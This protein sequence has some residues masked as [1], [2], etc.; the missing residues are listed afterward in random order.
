MNMNRPEQRYFGS[1]RFYKHLILVLICTVIL[2]LSITSIVLAVKNNQLKN[3]LTGY[4]ESDSTL[5]REKLAYQ[6]KYPQ[7]YVEEKSEPKVSPDKTIFLTFDDGPSDNTAVILDILDYY[8]IKAT[9]FVI[10]NGNEYEHR[11]YRDIVERGHSLAL[12]SYSHKY[13][14]IYKSVES[15]LDDFNKLYTFIEQETGFKPKIF[16]FPGGSINPYNVHIHQE[17]IAEMLRRGFIYHDWN[18][19]GND[20]SSSATTSSIYSSVVDNT[21]EF[22][23]SIVLL[24]DISDKYIT[25]RALESII[26]KLKSEGYRFDKLDGTSIPVTFAY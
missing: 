23:R 2:I 17:L 18:V 1:I 9:F 25:V 24:H 14:E 26:V 10:Y 7:L 13:S 19:S 6:E 8:D 4:D 21:K 20:T 5:L 22:D 16:R 3:K 15:Y 11:L 12:H